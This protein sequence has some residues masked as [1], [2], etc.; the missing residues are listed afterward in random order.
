MKLLLD[1]ADDKADGFLKLVK[2]Y[3]YIKA[4]HI[5]TPDV[6]LLKEIK[7][8]IKA[9]RNAEKIKSGKIKGRPAEELLNEL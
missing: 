9:L 3:S 8:I 7:Q 4:E 2:Q 5:S 1:I 6:D